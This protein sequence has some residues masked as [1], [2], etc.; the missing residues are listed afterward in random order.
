MEDFGHFVIEKFL[1]FAACTHFRIKHTRHSYLI[2]HILDLGPTLIEVPQVENEATVDESIEHFYSPPVARRSWIG[3][4]S[5]GFGARGT[6]RIAY[7][8]WWKQ[9]GRPGGQ[10]E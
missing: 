1:I 5:R 9:F 3:G 2:G 8:N 10:I 6:D 4:A 7:A